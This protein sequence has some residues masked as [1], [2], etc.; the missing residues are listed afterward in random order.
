M[1]KQ[2][3]RLKKIAYYTILIVVCFEVALW[4]LG[5]RPYTNVD[6]KVESQPNNAFLGDRLL[7][8][9]L[10]P[11]TYAITL[12]DSVKFTATHLKNNQRLVPAT[13][14]SNTTP[15]QTIHFMGCSFTYGYG[16]NDAETYVN[17]CQKSFPNSLVKNYGVMGYGTIQ[18]ALQLNQIADPTT[19]KLK[20]ND[21]VLL[22]FSS[23]HF[24]RNSL[25]QEY[26]SRLK[27]GY[28]NSSKDLQKEM[29]LA[30]FPMRSS[31]ANKTT[32]VKWIKM[33][34][35]WFGRDYFASINFLQ[36]TYD[37]Y[38]DSKTEEIAITQCLIEEMANK[39]AKNKVKFAVIC[40]NQNNRTE[41]LHQ[42]LPT[43]RWLDI[44]FDFSNKNITN[45]PYDSHPN[46]K[47]HL[48]IHHKIHP[49]L[50]QLL[51]K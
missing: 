33:Y 20:E 27:I 32:F 47:G 30:N 21:I 3:K 43:I 5:F 25:S 4:I 24:M 23:H 37:R 41:E 12:N 9:K 18:S 11:G 13:N 6:Y 38:I 45:L 35:N 29:D 31:C 26:R 44:G 2:L 16:V 17:L 42:N 28:E 36:S 7:G 50:A 14:I 51:S 48:F 10:N 49:F 22:C 15:T 46:S 8:I 34:K 19:A 39:C 40:L 1:Q